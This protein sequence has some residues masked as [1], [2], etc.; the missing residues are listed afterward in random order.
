MGLSGVGLL[1][2]L[3]GSYWNPTGFYGIPT[4]VV[5]PRGSENWYD[6]MENFVRDG[7]LSFGV[8]LISLGALTHRSTSII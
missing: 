6:H 1:L 7:R 5:T 4:G 8:T 2:N 3:M